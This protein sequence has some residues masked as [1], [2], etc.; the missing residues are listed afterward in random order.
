MDP[1]EIQ[2]GEDRVYDPPF[3]LRPDQVTDDMKHLAR[4]IIKEFCWNNIPVLL[5]TF[6]D[7]GIYHPL[8]DDERAQR[9][10]PGRILTI[11]AEVINPLG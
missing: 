1:S 6:E 2:F 9:N 11:I 5:D 8:L 4:T 10:N 3:R 7:A